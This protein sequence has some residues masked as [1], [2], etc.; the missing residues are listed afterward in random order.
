MLDDRLWDDVG[1]EWSTSR[2]AWLTSKDVERW[3]KRD[4]R[5]VIH[6]FG[7]PMQWLEPAEAR[8]WWARAKRH[9]EVPGQHSAEGD[10]EGLT[11]GAHVWRRGDARLLG[12][13]TFC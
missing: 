2:A 9:L 4:Q 1:R 11:W 8:A 10:E 6:G 13:E 5:V 7:Q 12:F 3:I